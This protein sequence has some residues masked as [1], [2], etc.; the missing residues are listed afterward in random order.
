METDHSHF[1]QNRD[2]PTK[3]VVTQFPD[4]APADALLFAA[5]GPLP[6]TLLLKIGR[7]LHG[8]LSQQ[9]AGALVV[10]L[11]RASRKKDSFGPMHPAP[12]WMES[13]DLER[14]T[15]SAVRDSEGVNNSVLWRTPTQPL[16]Q[17]VTR[18]VPRSVPRTAPEPQPLFL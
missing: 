3:L 4:T 11:P 1:A 15:S 17:K 12:P 2:R 10:L 13:A 14:Q 6:K 5:S 8:E 7:P 16:L 9:Q 18:S